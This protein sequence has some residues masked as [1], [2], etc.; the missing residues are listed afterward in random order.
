MKTQ[1]RRLRLTEEEFAEYEQ[2]IIKFRALVAALQQV[3][4]LSCMLWSLGLLHSLMLIARWFEPV[5]Y[6]GSG[7]CL[8]GIC[9]CL[10]ALCFLRNGS[11]FSFPGVLFM[12]IRRQYEAKTFFFYLSGL[13]TY[14]KVLPSIYTFS[15]YHDVQELRTK[16]TTQETGGAESQ[17]LINLQLQLHS[18]S[19]KHESRQLDMVC[20]YQPWICDHYVTEILFW[21]RSNPQKFSTSSYIFLT[22]SFQ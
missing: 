7:T 12:K 5:A 11:L 19:A 16:S 21:Y 1:D 4:S 9:V 10:T 13:S 14:K 3:C 2:T 18:S 22:N 6:M 17:Q 8:R 15:P 20:T